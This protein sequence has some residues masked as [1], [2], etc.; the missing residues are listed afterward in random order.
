MKSFS[1]SLLT[2]MTTGLLLFCLGSSGLELSPSDPQV[3][4]PIDSSFNI[5]CSGLSEV[6]WRFRREERLSEFH[7]EKRSSSSSVLSLERVTWRH[8]G[9]YVCSENG[10]DETREVAVFVPD[11][12]VWF[13]ENDHIMVTKTREEGTIPCLVTN[14]LINVTLYEKDTEVMVEGSYNPIVGFT[15][16]L[17]DRNYKCKGELNGEEKE[18]I[19]FYVFSIVAP[20]ALDPYINASKTVLKQGETLNVNCT[21]HGAELVFFSWDFPHK[22][23]GDVEPLTDVLSSMSMRSCLNITDVTLARSGQ[24]VC[25]VH[26][27]VE[28]Q[29]ASASINITVLE[30]GFVALSSHLD[31]NISAQLG[32]N[33]ELKVEVEAYPKPSIQWSKDGAAIRGHSTRQ[34]QETRFIST[35]TLVRIRLE[36][37]GL[38]TVTVQNQ[39]DSK[40]ITFDLEVKVPPQITELSDHQLPGKKHAVTCVAEGVPSPSIQW[41]SCDS[42]HKC[43]NRSVVWSPLAEDPEKVSI[44]TN[45][46]YNISRKIHLVHSQLTLLRP[47][48]LSIR[49]EAR[50]ERGARSR[51]I[52]LVNST[53]FSQVAVLATVLA[54]VVIVIISI[55]ILIAVWRKKP[56]YEIRWKVIESVSLDGHEYIYVDPIHLPYDLAWEMPRD[57]LVL[58]R[59]LG[60][61]AFGRVVEATAYGLGRSQ[62][63]TK[64]A[65]KMLKS[66]ARRSETQAL[67]SELKIM[68]HL[69][70]HLNIVNLLGACTKHGPLY[71]VTEYC[72]YGDLVDYLHRNKHS[73]LQYYADKNHIAN[74]SQICNDSDVPPGKEYVSFGSECDGGYMDM[75][76]DEQTEYVAMQELTDTIKYADIQPSPYESPY[77]Q[78][79]YQEQ[80]HRVDRSLVIS[81]SPVLSYTDLVGFSYQVA[82]GME[83]LASKNCVHR[84]LA[85]RNVLIC[86]G[87]LAKICDFG[88]ARDIMHDNNYISKGSTF[89]PLKWMAPESIFHN[90]YTTLSD[91]WSYGIL[92]W[93]I[94]TLGGTPYP[95]LPMNELFY[96]AL[97][98]GY[99]MTK[100][101]YASDDVYEVMRKCWDE[102]FEK[103]PEFSFLVHTMGN[104]LSDGYKKKYSQV[105][106]SFLKSDHPAVARGK[107][108]VPSPFPNTFSPQSL[109]SNPGPDLS[110]RPGADGESTDAPHNEYIIPIPDPKPEEHSQDGPVLM[111]IPSSSLS[112]DEETVS[113]ETPS[114]EPER[115]ELLPDHSGSLEVEESFL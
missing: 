88:L 40:E 78:D 14:P 13:L 30:K 87:K 11:P 53:L 92:L 84:D 15:A 49:C 19:G 56:R 68:S 111:E 48:L 24:Y 57:S 108:C 94:F 51:D 18:S 62:S 59:T 102:K 41:F 36:Q 60:S 31:R 55:I 71:L 113:M 10:T 109:S 86:E 21:V 89:L 85:A 70:P 1:R 4:L 73:F 81:D 43:S 95:D 17:E 45:V 100:P 32:E 115:E 22:D 82:K 3:V 110:P 20:E 25:H 67:M 27:G 103:R 114:T 63:T 35:L 98:R 46:S 72:R 90:L 52:R 38:Y 47:Q 112:S 66:T 12:E 80:G 76:K 23:V 74:G 6:T 34:E 26:E 106:D 2:A 91:V 9:V 42:M 97:K 104:M 64:V 61:G 58:G 33:V 8:T 37:M 29:R 77:Q 5:T 93:E 54:L 7:V 83:F 105:S 96:S 44:Q 50:N 28:D 79:I 107:P 101:S 65:V 39:D 75:T 99:R 69:G 16:A